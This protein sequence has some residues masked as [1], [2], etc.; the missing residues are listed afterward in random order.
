MLVR[1]SILAAASGS[2]GGT[3]AAHNRGGA[4]IRARTVPT[5][6]A[7]GFQVTMRTILGNLATAWQ[8]ITEAQRDAWT[9]YALNCPITN[10]LGDPVTLTGQQMYVRCNAA[11][12][13]AGLAR[14]D[15]GPIIFAMDSLSPVTIAP[16]DTADEL[17]VGFVEADDWVDE[18]NA[19]LLLYGSRQF[20]PTINFHKGPYRFT[21]IIE[22]DA[23]TPPT[24]PSA[25]TSVFQL[26]QDNVV[27]C[28]VLSVR[29]DG[30]ISPSQF[31]GPNI[32][33]A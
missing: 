6:P 17:G 27:F 24:T 33:G 8:V 15:D 14:V 30:R 1:F 2:M 3:T 5:D 19:G 11:R 4:Y 26:D 12:V 7:S 22:G 9:T 28:R 20:A 32:I 13:Q 29:A 31:I 18:D 23:I 25:E 16:L 10:P 21:S